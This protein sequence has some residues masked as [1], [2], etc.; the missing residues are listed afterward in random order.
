MMAATEKPFTKLTPSHETQI[1][2]LTCHQNNWLPARVQLHL[3]GNPFAV[4]VGVP[5]SLRLMLFVVPVNVRRFHKRNAEVALQVAVVALTNLCNG[6]V[7]LGCNNATLVT[8]HVIPMQPW[9]CSVL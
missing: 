8:Q 3:P 5:P 7:A 2:C 6:S 1:A 9:L 4:E